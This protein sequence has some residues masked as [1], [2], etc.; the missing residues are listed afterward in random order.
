MDSSITCGDEQKSADE[1]SIIM[2]IYA[3][4]LIKNRSGKFS[5]VKLFKSI[6]HHTHLQNFITDVFILS[7]SESDLNEIYQTLMEN[8]YHVTAAIQEMELHL[9]TSGSTPGRSMSDIITIL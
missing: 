9:K 3:E 6:E 7:R 5:V 8:L 4:R 2:N 1:M